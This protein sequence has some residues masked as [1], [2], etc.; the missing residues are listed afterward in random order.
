MIS[1]ER[2]ETFLDKAIAIAPDHTTLI[3]YKGKMYERTDRPEKAA[4]I[5]AGLHKA[6]R[7]ASTTHATTDST[8]T[9]RP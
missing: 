6:I 3:E 5:F 8:S 1:D 2:M 9:T 4:K 7:R